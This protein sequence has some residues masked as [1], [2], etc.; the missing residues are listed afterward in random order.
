[1]LCYD[2]KHEENLIFSFH[3][4]SGTQEPTTTKNTFCTM[5]LHSMKPLMMINL[6]YDSSVID[7]H[8][9]ISWMREIFH[10]RDL[11]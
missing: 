10:N 9:A 8:G 5:P 7:K 11:N 1:M 2:S 3:V 4:I 6:R